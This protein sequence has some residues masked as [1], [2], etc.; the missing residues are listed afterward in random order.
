MYNPSS[1]IYIFRNVTLISCK[2]DRIFTR[3]YPPAGRFPS[4]ESFFHANEYLTQLDGVKYSRWISLANNKLI[5]R[6][7]IL[8]AR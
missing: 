4:N 5:M 2:R 3:I 7:W 1:L 8:I 6:K